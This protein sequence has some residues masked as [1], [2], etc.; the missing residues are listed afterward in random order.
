MYQNE[1]N[2]YPLH[3][4]CWKSI[5]F[6]QSKVFVSFFT[7]TYPYLSLGRYVCCATDTNII[8]GGFRGFDGTQESARFE[9]VC[10]T[11]LINI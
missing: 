1:Q 6:S 7:S 9:Q 5:A 2:Q 11:I 3:Y 8:A 10:V 4:L